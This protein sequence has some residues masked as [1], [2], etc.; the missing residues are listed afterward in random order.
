MIKN[1]KWCSKCMSSKETILFTKNRARS[2]GV[3]D[4]CKDCM[5]KYHE[6]I[7][8]RIRNYKV[9]SDK[10]HM[11]EKVVKTKE[12]RRQ[13]PEKVR[14][15]NRSNAQKYK[16][17]AIRAYSDGKNCCACCDENNIKFLS[18]DHMNDDGASHRKEVGSGSNM[19]VWLHTHAYPK[20][21]QVLCFN[22]N[23]GRSVNGG[24]CPHK[25]VWVSMTAPAAS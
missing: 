2:S 18:I 3:A 6:L 14:Q 7:P 8:D 1:E 21:F 12:W 25:E 16:L 20:G 11:A 17:S 13:N 10:K 22:C 5:K 15:Y 9:R 23:L 4:W 19:H 24:V